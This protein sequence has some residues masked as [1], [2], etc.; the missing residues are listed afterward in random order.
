MA[1]Q[2]RE[3]KRH[4]WADWCRP[5]EYWPAVQRLRP[6]LNIRTAVYAGVGVLTLLLV[7]V[8]SGKVRETWSDYTGAARTAKIVAISGRLAQAGRHWAIERGLVYAGLHTAGGVTDAEMSQIDA[9]A[10]RGFAQYRAALSELASRSAFDL[11]KLLLETLRADVR[12][13]EALRRQVHAALS[14]RPTRHEHALANR[15]MTAATKAITSAQQVALALS[16]RAS[17]DSDVHRILLLQRHSWRTAEYLGRERAVIAGLIAL[18]APANREQLHALGVATGR[19]DSALSAMQSLH[20]SLRVAPGLE[21]ALKKASNLLSGEFARLRRD[22]REAAIRGAAYPT[23]AET[24]FQTATTAINALFRVQDAALRLARERAEEAR[25]ATSSRVRFDATIVVACLT[26][27]L[28]FIVFIGDR[29]V[30]PLRAITRGLHQMAAGGSD[31]DLPESRR[32]DEIGALTGAIRAFRE[33]AIERRRL[34]AEVEARRAAEDHLRAAKERA[35]A[36]NAAKSQFLA[37]VSHEL[38]T[39]LNAVIGFSEVLQ[40]GFKGPLNEGQRDYVNDILNSARHLLA[41]IND[42][43]EFSKA[44]SGRLVPAKTDVPVAE[45]V[46]GAVRQVAQRAAKEDIDLQV[47]ADAAPDSIYADERMLTQ[48]LLNLLINAIRFTPPG[49]TVTLGVRRLAGG[50]EFVVADTGVGMEPSQISRALE[51]FHQLDNQPQNA[52]GTGLGL[53]M[54]KRLAELHGGRLD[55]ESAPDRGTTARVWLPDGK[56][57]ADSP[58]GP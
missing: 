6:S 29:V 53:P 19:A 39:P 34:E 17:N 21:A 20:T 54:V 5:R 32:S 7:G 43:L 35:E 15:W 52:E 50:S 2:E 45:A 36:A 16:G 9:H 38:R 1:S 46:E 24:W 23:S 22:S 28:V 25:A 18:N 30:S 49:G 42:V 57:D 47:D 58:T 40:A 4:G 37:N 13:V 12:R 55:I 51:V 10:G 27:G 11:P 44:E 48:I 56:A 33:N 31:V 8:S 26:L 3:A 14:A 41:L